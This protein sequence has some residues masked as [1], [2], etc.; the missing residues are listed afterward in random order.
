VAADS[1]C[2]PVCFFNA[3]DPERLHSL[4]AMKGIRSTFRSLV[5][6]TSTILIFIGSACSPSNEGNHEMNR[7]EIEAKLNGVLQQMVSRCADPKDREALRAAEVFHNL[8]GL[9]MDIVGFSVP[10][11]SGSNRAHISF[12]SDHFQR[13]RQETLAA[14][15][16]EDLQTAKANSRKGPNG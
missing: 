6:L 7:V 3:V 5:C 11:N 16:L 10:I 9:S 15:G 12:T 13:T 2:A 8:Q 4:L 14:E 1:G